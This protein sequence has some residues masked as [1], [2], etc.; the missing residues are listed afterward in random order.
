MLQSKIKVRTTRTATS[1]RSLETSVICL[2]RLIAFSVLTNA[3][4][5]RQ[6]DH[7]N[8][9]APYGMRQLWKDL[10][11]SIWHDYYEKMETGEAYQQRSI[12]LLLWEI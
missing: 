3:P 6:K 5:A 1:S 4:P 12:L 7:L 9:T 10:N 2:E 8:K 11:V